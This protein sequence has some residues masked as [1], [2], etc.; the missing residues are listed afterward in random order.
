MLK[1]TYKE[2]KAAMTT[3]F[4]DIKENMLIRNKKTKNSS[5]KQKQKR[6][7]LAILDL[8]EAEE[9]QKRW[10]EYTE[11]LYKERLND[12][13]NHDSVVIYLEPDILECE[14]K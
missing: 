1:F 3:M 2:F 11:K 7:K 13:D 4:K 5:D 10:Q 14:V 8:T 12:I 9:I 6:S